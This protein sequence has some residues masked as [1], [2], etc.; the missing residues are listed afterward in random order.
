MLKVFDLIDD[1][2]DEHENDQENKKDSF[3]LFN[4]LQEEL[5]KNGFL[6]AMMADTRLTAAEQDATIIPMDHQ[7]KRKA[8]QKK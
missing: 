5:A 7:S 4:D 2:E 6:S 1:Y 8:G 3:T